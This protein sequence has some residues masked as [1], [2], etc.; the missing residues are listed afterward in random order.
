MNAPQAPLVVIVACEGTVKEKAKQRLR[1]VAKKWRV[2]TEGSSV[3]HGRDVVW[4]VMD[5]TRWAAWLKSMY[6][7]ETSSSNEES[8]D[9]GELDSLKV[10]IA[11]H[12]VTSSALFLN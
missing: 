7:M 8:E 10:I 12:K 3:V 11:D 5:K 4:T 9:R 6:G 1:D 2:R